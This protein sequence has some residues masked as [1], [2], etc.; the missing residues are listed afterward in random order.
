MSF[1]TLADYEVAFPGTISDEA[2]RSQAVAAL[3][4][5]CEDIRRYCSQTFDL[6]EGDVVTLHGTGKSTVL[7]PELPV[8]AV[9]TVTIDKDLD[10]EEVITEFKIDSATGILYRSPSSTTSWGLGWPWGFAN[11]TVDYDHGYAVIPANLINVAVGLAR[12][13]IVSGPS[14][15]RSETIAGYGYTQDAGQ[16]SVHDFAAVLEPFRV[17]HVPVA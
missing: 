1:A 6:V 17:K 10:T 9:N 12:E 13:S 7:L 3:A 16:A 2:G 5:A 4:A 8:V 11:I 14:R 15:L